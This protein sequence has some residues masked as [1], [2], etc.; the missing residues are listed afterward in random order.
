M[1]K[2]DIQVIETIALER[3]MPLAEEKARDFLCSDCRDVRCQ[4]GAICNAFK[5]TSRSFAWEIVAA[6]AELN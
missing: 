5:M 6:N 3:V 4:L 1:N 2:C